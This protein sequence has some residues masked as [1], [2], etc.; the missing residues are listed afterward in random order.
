MAS[1]L[2]RSWIFHTST[3]RI[4]I[5]R[6]PIYH[7]I[8]SR[9]P[10]H[11]F[12]HNRQRPFSSC[13]L[14]R[15][16]HDPDLLKSIDSH[17]P[18]GKPR[19][20]NDKAYQEIYAGLNQSY[21]VP[22][23]RL[24]LKTHHHNIK[25]N[26]NKAKKNE[27]LELI[28]SD[29][30]GFPS[31]TMVQQAEQKRKRDTVQTQFKIT[32][33]E[34]FF[35]IG[36]EGS[37]LRRIEQVNN[38]HITIMVDHDQY[39][40]EGLPRNIA[41]AHQEIKHCFKQ[42][43]QEEV[44]LSSSLKDGVTFQ[45]LVTKVMPVIPSISKQCRTFISI[46]DDKFTF[47]ALSK[48][49]M[50]Q[51]KLFLAQTISEL[52]VTNKKSLGAANYTF[53][54][55]TPDANENF[56]FMPLHDSQAMPLVIKPFGWSRIRR[57][58]NKNEPQIYSSGALSFFNI[59]DGN[60]KSNGH[61]NVSGPDIKQLITQELNTSTE[62]NDTN[63]HLEA[64]FGAILY[65]N[66]KSKKSPFLSTPQNNIFDASTL[67][68]HTSAFKGQRLFLGMQPP[69]NITAPFFPV[70]SDTGGIHRRSVVLE[71]INRDN[72]VSF[73]SISTSSLPDE[74]TGYHR[75]R[76]EFLVQE[77]GSVVL[78]KAEGERKR[79]VVDLM[80]V[81]GNV[82]VRLS[83][84]KHLAF[85]SKEITKIPDFYSQAPLP[86][87]LK[88]LVDQCELT[89][90]SDFYCPSSFILGSPMDLLEVSFR[91]EARY[92]TEQSLVTLSNIDAQYSQS[93]RTELMVTPVRDEEL[94][95]SLRGYSQP[96]NGLDRWDS[97]IETVRHIARRWHYSYNS[98]RS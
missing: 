33:P 77:D 35:T 78:E 61:A 10:I 72:L 15:T 82:D 95:H 43:I 38:V 39:V 47:A 66:P 18:S 37:T 5:S 63:V 51:A 76:I 23:L 91:D 4:I 14:L 57:I 21:T 65:E 11:C 59:M 86:N 92:V 25:F 42:M 62:V 60:S 45:D 85:N 56:E 87:T 69:A 58:Q 89:G 90:Y 48:Q 1:S 97:F 54:N 55:V 8:S 84:K 24:Y 88:A 26:I 50:D 71:Y 68:D 36:D 83:A 53:L 75:V 74:P 44:S 46:K 80:A 13:P 16:K 7:S 2:T 98:F 64:R 96:S 94:A 22:Q 41:K 49:S 28:V 3:Q 52:D 93:R 70:M 12:H 79:T 32:K 29:Y 81:S 6:R 19:A 73:N 40:I 9:T 17:R 30:W 31:R 20:I 67:K 34:L 27:L